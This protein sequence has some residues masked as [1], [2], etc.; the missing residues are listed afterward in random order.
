MNIEE[1][2]G[3]SIE[4]LIA[5][6]R[7]SF[8][9]NIVL[10][11]S[12]IRTHKELAYLAFESKSNQVIEYLFAYKNLTIHAI[13][14]KQSPIPFKILEET[15]KN[16]VFSLQYL[17]LKN[18]YVLTLFKNSENESDF[19]TFFNRTYFSRKKSLK[20]NYVINNY[21]DSFLDFGHVKCAMSLSKSY[22]IQDLL[23]VA[24][25]RLLQCANIEDIVSK[26]DGKIWFY[27]VKAARFI[28]S[29]EH[30]EL[31]TI[32]LFGDNDLQLVGKTQIMKDGIGKIAAA[33]EVLKR[34]NV[35]RFNKI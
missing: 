15:Y 20:D 4:D 21:S 32:T 7:N 18:S 31:S 24:W 12:D 8:S 23:D 16:A 19:T 6:K 10:Q 22:G 5:R 13:D 34:F 28:F 29:V 27:S 25:N 35:N 33:L 1:F 3:C 17:K 11:N 9:R 2:T 30:P 26:K 14:E